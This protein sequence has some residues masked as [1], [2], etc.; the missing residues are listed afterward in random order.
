MTAA[1]QRR[2]HRTLPLLL[3][4]GLLLAWLPAS[5]AWGDAREISDDVCSPPYESDFDDIAGSAHEE[6]IR[7]MADYNLAEGV[8]DGSSYAPRRDVTRGQMAS[9]V[10]RFLADYTGQPLPEGDADRF[11]DVPQDDR[12]YP[13][14]TNIHSL[15]EIGVVE[16]T[17]ASG[18]QSYA[19]QRGVT[20]AQMASM[21]RRALAWAD[22]ENARNDSAPPAG[23]P[24]AFTDTAGSVH[25]DNID[26]LAEAGIVQ[27]FGDDTYRPGNLVK[28]DQMASFVMRSYD[29]AVAEE[30]GRED[31]DEDD[32]QDDPEEPQPGPVAILSPTTESP[33]FPVSPGDEVDI[34]F[35][36]DRA[37]DY[38]LEFRDPNP[39]PDNGFFLIP[40]DDDGP[41]D[42]TAFEGDDASG[43]VDEGD[44][45]DVAVTLPAGEE[46]EG[47]RDIR[48]S[49]VPA[50]EPA[51]TVANQQDAAII[52]GDGVVI[53]L[54]Q[55]RVDFEIQSAVD[56]A[57]DNDALLAIGEFEET[58][59][60]DNDGL[61][62]SGLG[63]EDTVLEGTIILEGVTGVMVGDLTVTGYDTLSALE[64]GII[65]EEIG[66]L[67]DEASDIALERL[68]L[69]GSGSGSDDIG[70]AIGSEVDG[71]EVS[72]SMLLE[73]GTAIRAG[74]E[75]NLTAN[76]FEGNGVAVVLEGEADGSTIADS[77][78][79]GN[80]GAI[81]V[82]EA[83][84]VTIEGNDFDG[85]DE[86]TI[87]LE[88]DARF[89][90]IADN[91]FGDDTAEHIR[92]F[93]NDYSSADEQAFLDDN[94]YAS[95]PEVVDDDGD[96]VIQPQEEDENGE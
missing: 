10:A 4:L 31:D 63:T 8:G 55:E 42:W 54:T 29:Y 41:G 61:L 1:L 87:H 64:L 36:T 39:D 12:A 32:E 68:S 85:H 93:A 47:V 46:N 60:V 6:M 7:C 66:I 90:T 71:V 72:G 58:V 35:R 50:D 95:E 34:T 56:E 67:V 70:I 81:L 78:F 26:A 5:G 82:E 48:L 94:I 43:T 91:Q 73:N 28:R 49:F 80:D 45:F 33:A 83:N 14:S 88:E 17:S 20:R 65:G 18:G 62:L 38:E 40:G 96:R 23:E 75:A 92:F 22:D 37:G 30:L 2:R 76:D 89:A 77:D 51:T 86:F 24:G 84:E 19:P 27:G 52:V 74:S 15:A 13:H 9:F 25:E 3:A 21:I 57:D 53:N 44:T 59:E 79:K 69:E 11:D 16:G